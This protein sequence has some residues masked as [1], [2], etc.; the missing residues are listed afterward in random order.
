MADPRSLETNESDCSKNY[1]SKAVT[2]VLSG[3]AI[4]PASAIS[5]ESVITCPQCGKVKLETMPT[6]S[7]QFFYECSSCG[8]VLRPKQGHCC[9]FCSYGSVLC[10]SIRQQSG[11]CA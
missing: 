10:P 7:C 4:G 2:S 9:V 6:E 1:D 8:V 11:C 5:L 3:E